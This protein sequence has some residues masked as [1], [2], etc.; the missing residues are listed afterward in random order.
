[1]KV[2]P[3]SPP[4]PRHPERWFMRLARPDLRVCVEVDLYHLVFQNVDDGRFTRVQSKVQLLG[5]ESTSLPVTP[6]SY[7]G[8][9]NGGEKLDKSVA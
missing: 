1:M 9:Q 5:H 4:E 2:A 8:D 6:N 7:L 3:V